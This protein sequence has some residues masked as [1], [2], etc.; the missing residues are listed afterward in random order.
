MIRAINLNK[1]YQQ[2]AKE[3]HVLKDI[4]LE[5]RK[6]EFVVIVGPSGAGK[7]TLLHIL[8]GLDR[9][10]T[11]NIMFDKIDL[12]K[13]NDSQRAKIRNA[14]IGFVFQSYHLMHE[15]NAFENVF[16]PALIDV[17]QSHNRSVNQAKNRAKE[18]LDKLGLADRLQHKPNQLSGG[19][20]QRVAIA[21]ALMNSPGVL[22][23]DEPTGNLDSKTG[24]EVFNVLLKLNKEEGVT[25]LMV[26]HEESLA[27]EADRVLHMKDG[28]IL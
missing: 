4:N 24:I 23:C 3:L 8:A 28:R 26:T 9:P 25:C 14:K 5:I 19:E 21:R 20:Q 7:S 15:F 16:M 22:Y 1:I 6:S 10:T 11:G 2:G 17:A 27:F 12:Y 18:L 13:I